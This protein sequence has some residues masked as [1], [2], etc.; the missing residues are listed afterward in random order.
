LKRKNRA[1]PTFEKV[2][3]IDL[4]AEGQAIAKI[5]QDVD[6]EKEFVIFVDKCV[7]GDIVDIQ[8]IKKQRNFM[9]AFPVRFHKLSD[10]RISPKCEHFGVCGG[11]KWQSLSY[12]VQLEYKHKQVNDQLKHIG[13]IEIP[14]TFQ[15]IGSEDPYF[16][17]NKLEFTFSNKRWLLPEEM[18]DIP[19]EMDAL[20]FHIPGKFDKVLD[21]KNCYL[22][23]G[24][25]NEIRKAVKTF[26]RKLKLS[27]F[28]LRQQHG[29][30]R[31]LIIRN[32]G[33]TNDL[34]VIVSFFEDDRTKRELFLNK[35]ASEFPEISSLMY[36]VNPKKNDTI[37]DLPVKLFKGKDH[38]IEK[39]EDLSFKVGPKSFF[40]TNSKQAFKLYSFVREFASLS[41]NEIVYDLYT[42]TGTIA[43]FISFQAA[44][45]VGIDYISE[46]I[47]D[48]KENSR[49]NNITNTVFYAGDMK[50]IL[51]KGFMDKN[52]Y[53]DVI[54]LDPPRA[55]IHKDVI[56][57]I[58]EANAKR[59]VYVSCNAATQARDIQ[60]LSGKYRV[61]KSQPVD[62]FPQTAHVENVILLSSN[63]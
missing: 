55:G 18:D 23:G 17:R 60:L 34:M 33:S 2:E 11:C 26:A 51:N 35:I 40:Q 3:I 45:V 39:M 42:G 38:I 30:L 63:G 1:L 46:A 53:P 27:F 6:N 50:D 15:I 59:I 4:A 61:L 13:R 20:G 43:N 48:A 21:I 14:E 28:D 58:S 19:S 57:V 5:K 36:V 44:K 47:D 10:L 7:P 37:S 32:S 29:L 8:V 31:N 24:L 62:M 41:G 9:Q 16:Y 56:D 25:S 49:L 22:Q 54:I 12:N 52:G